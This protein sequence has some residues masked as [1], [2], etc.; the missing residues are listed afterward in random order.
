MLPFSSPSLSSITELDLR[1]CSWP[2]PHVTQGIAKTFP[3]LVTLRMRQQKIWCTMC[4]TCDIPQFKEPGPDFI[5]YNDVRGLPVGTITLKLPFS[6]L[7]CW[8]ISDIILKPFQ[9][10]AVF[11]LY[12]LLLGACV[13]GELFF[14]PE[15]QTMT[16]SGPANATVA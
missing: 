9:P 13:L 10:C 12:I 5:F 8:I 7:I 6:P 2:S 4:H 14:A 11:E 1:G 3:S 15:T 16:F